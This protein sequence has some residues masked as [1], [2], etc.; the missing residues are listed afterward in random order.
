MAYASRT[1]TRR[2]LAALRAAGWRLMV[3]AKGVLRTEGFRYALDNGAWTAFQQQQPFDVPA[4]ERAVRELGTGA[5]FVVVPDIVAG[6]LES[7][8]FSLDWLPRLSGLRLLAVQDGMTEDDVAPHI[9]RSV[10]VFVGGS[11]PFKEHTMAGW[12]KLARSRGAYCHVGRVN[13]VRRIRQCAD[14]GVDS[15]DGSSASRF[16]L[17]VPRMEAARRQLSLL[18]RAA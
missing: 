13:T 6:G 10:G 9:G 5:D 16:A 15:F 3:S 14:A 1:G 8:A 12:A 4:F 7:L 11:T 17:M 18:G 2:N